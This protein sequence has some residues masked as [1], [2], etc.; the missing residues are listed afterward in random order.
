MDSPSTASALTLGSTSSQGR[1]PRAPGSCLRGRLPPPRCRKSRRAGRSIRSSATPSDPLGTDTRPPPESSPPGLR[2]PAGKSGGLREPARS[3]GSGWWAAGAGLVVGRGPGSP[4][5]PRAL[6]LPGLLGSLG[7]W[8]F[9]GWLAEHEKAAGGARA[10]PAT[11]ATASCTAKRTL[12]R[13]PLRPG[14]GPA[15][16][17]SR[18]R[19]PVAR[20]Q[21]EGAPHSRRPR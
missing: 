6:A 5:V 9:S 2:S 8:F 4:A 7:P 16:S 18:V 20:Y 19:M 17:T 15:Q 12:Q 13:Y 3:G 10:G 21:H 11:V 14:P 1:R